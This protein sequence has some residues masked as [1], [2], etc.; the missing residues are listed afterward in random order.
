MSIARPSEDEFSP[1]H[2]TYIS[3]VPVD[4]DPVELMRTQINLLSRLMKA[5]SEAQSFF[6][7]APHKWSIKEV[8][9]HLSD[10][11]R[12]MSCR[13]LRIARGDRTPLPGFEE[14]DYVRAANF[15][16]R[17]LS[18]LVEEWVDVRRATLALV[19]GIE[20]SAWMHRGIANT[21]E[22]S[23]RAL[24]YI[25]PG[26]VAHHIDLLQSRYGLR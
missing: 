26:H 22:V 18:S 20:H 19:A 23:A 25:I 4:L 8:V 14:D 24:G 5:V 1:Y 3:R 2:L 13:L 10:T 16:A 6:R 7:Y 21:K 11:E 9:G 12:I 15:D 17:A